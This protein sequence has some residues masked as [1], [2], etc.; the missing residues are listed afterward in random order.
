LLDARNEFGEAAAI[1]FGAHR[2]RVER[3]VMGGDVDQRSFDA[4]GLGVAEF[5]RGK[6]LTM[7][8]QEP[9]MVEHGLEDQRLAPGHGGTV[10]TMDR[11]LSQLRARHD[12]GLAADGKASCPHALRLTAAGPATDLRPRH[13]W[14]VR[15]EC[16]ACGGPRR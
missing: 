3:A 12:I 5:D 6:V 8:L 16:P 13:P 14:I 10:A 2:R 4:L 7:L 15:L 11:A 1:E 9:G